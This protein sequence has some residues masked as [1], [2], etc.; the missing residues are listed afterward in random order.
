MK[1]TKKIEGAQTPDIGEENERNSVLGFRERLNGD[2]VF[3][4]TS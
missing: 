2:L 4:T 1:A 3:F